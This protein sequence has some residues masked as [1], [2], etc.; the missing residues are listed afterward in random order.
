MKGGIKILDNLQRQRKNPY[1]ADHIGKS[2]RNLGNSEKSSLDELRQ[3][4][5]K[6]KWQKTHIISAYPRFQAKNSEISN[7]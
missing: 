7:H 4:M 3:I 6:Q 1:F 2:S 5:T